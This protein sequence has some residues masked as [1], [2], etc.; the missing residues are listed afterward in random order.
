MTDVAMTVMEK[1]LTDHLGYQVRVHNVAN[2]T[3]IYRVVPQC[4][5]LVSF[6]EQEVLA[7][8][9]TL[10]DFVKR[11]IEDRLRPREFKLVKVPRSALRVVGGNAVLPT[12]PET[13]YFIGGRIPQTSKSGT[14]ISAYASKQCPSS[15]I[16]LALLDLVD[17]VESLG[18]DITVVAV[19]P[20]L[21]TYS[22]DVHGSQAWFDGA[23]LKGH[24][25]WD[26]ER[27]LPQIMA[28]D[29]TK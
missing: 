11:K 3:T 21:R 1:A 26:G 8:N 23:V 19:E 13:S 9:S 4:V 24:W 18:P 27:L 25:T 28:T 20:G 22:D 12:P 7:E 5:E 29:A 2:T 14:P 10:L 16:D 6:A 17:L 15:C